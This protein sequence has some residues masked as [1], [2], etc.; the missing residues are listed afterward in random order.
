MRRKLCYLI[1]IILLPYIVTVFING[2]GMTVSS[3]VDGVYVAVKLEDEEQITM[4]LEEYCIGLL[5]KAIPLDYEKEALKAQ[6]VLIRTDVYRQLQENGS[7]TVFEEDYWSQT[8][9]EDAWG[10]KYASYYHK[11]EE[12]WNATEG[13]VLYY[14]EDLAYAPYFRLSNGSTRDGAE[15][16]GSE[17]YPYL[18][19]VDC[20]LDLESEE[21]LRI[22]TL[23]ELDAEITELD[24]AGYVLSVRVGQETVSGEEF[25]TAYDLDSSCFTL[26]NYDGRLRITTRG[27]G[28]GLGMSQYTANRMAEDGDTYEEILEYF[29]AGTQ[30]REVTDIVLME[31]TTGETA[32]ILLNEEKN[33]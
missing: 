3:Q 31:E 1:I 6:A 14:G 21:Q 8:E 5:A 19:M 27:V 10:M 15:V 20:P 16:M 18:K 32:E 13:Q 22:Q 29:F 30:L 25:R 2:P 17:E 28:H 23:A 12:V 7:S 11:L 26:Q 33:I 4:P 9:M 24:S